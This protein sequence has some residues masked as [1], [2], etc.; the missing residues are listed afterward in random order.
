VLHCHVSHL[1]E[2]LSGER[3]VS[4]IATRSQLDLEIFLPAGTGA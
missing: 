4:Q 3:R 2:A 1:T